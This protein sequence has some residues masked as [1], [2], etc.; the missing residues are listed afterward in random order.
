MALITVE[1]YGVLDS[2]VQE[3]KGS[4]P[5]IE[6]PVKPDYIPGFYL[7]VVVVSPRV[8]KPLGPG[9]VD[10]GKPT[11]RMGYLAAN[12]SDPYKQ[13]DVTVKT[14]RAVYKPRDTIKARIAK[15]GINYGVIVFLISFFDPL[16]YPRR[17]QS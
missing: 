12:V 9:N 16:Q 3:L 15:T 11:Y 8:A 14:E 6:I 7:S 1:R 17:Q 10:L 13:L 4:T 2:W 5:I